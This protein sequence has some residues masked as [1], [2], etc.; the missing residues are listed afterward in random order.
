[1]GLEGHVNILGRLSA[2]EMK[3]ELLKSSLFI[4]ASSLENSPNSMGEAM[5]L[6]VPVVAARTGGIPSMLEDGKE[7][8]LYEAGNVQQLAECVF[9]IWEETEETMRRAQAAKARAM[10]AH[11]GDKNYKRMLEIYREICQ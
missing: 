7:G 3:Q 10:D 11:N 6:G 2:E 1:M 4:C 9:K 5:L 8:L